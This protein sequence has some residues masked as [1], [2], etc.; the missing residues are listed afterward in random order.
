MLMD[1]FWLSLLLKVAVTVTV[2][3]STSLA[4]ERAGPFWGG[5]L[6][7]FPLSAGPA[8]V[9]LAL[10]ADAAFVAASALNSLGGNVGPA[11]ATARGW[12]DLPIRALMIGV[13]V[14]VV[15][16]VSDAIGPSWTGLALVFPF[17]LGSFTFVIH[18]RAGGAA[19]AAT[20]A[21]ALRALPGFAAA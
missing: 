5:L 15:L 4:V 6:C 14:A 10:Q 18:G 21:M 19:A 9:L 16:T 20:M 8:Y 13:L 7:A 3:M 12:I 17:A 2:V 1:A 11:P